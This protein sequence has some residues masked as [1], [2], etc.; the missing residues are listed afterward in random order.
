MLFF[1]PARNWR[2]PKDY[3]ALAD[4]DAPKH[5][6]CLCWI[7]TKI[8]IIS[9]DKQFFAALPKLLYFSGCGMDTTISVKFFS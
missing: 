9:I 5:K 4:Y 6:A 1:L 7:M 8:H 3:S 2:N